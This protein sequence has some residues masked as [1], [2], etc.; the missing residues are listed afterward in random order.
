[1]Q[2]RNRWAHRVAVV[3]SCLVVWNFGVTAASR[4]PGSNL[5]RNASFEIPAEHSRLPRHWSGPSDVYSIDTAVRRSGR[6]SLRFRNTDEK[7]Y[8]LCTQSVPV[9]PGRKYRFSVWVKT[10]RVAGRESGATICLEWNDKQGRWLGGSYPSGV[11]GT[12]DWTKVEGIAIIPENA[13][14]C[15]LTCYV[16]K[17]MT[18]TAWFDDVELEHVLDPPMRTVLLSPVYRGRLTREGPQRATVRI[19]LDLRDR[20]LDLGALSVNVFLRS[21]ETK[22][23]VWRKVFR[24]ESRSL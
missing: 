8:S 22:K 13:G 1:M 16:R 3:F 20:N 2:E 23:I 7:K 9:R 18:G 5:V 6:A 19:R 12:R 21:V 15:T 10:L 4:S 17:G 11:K 14:S 24:P